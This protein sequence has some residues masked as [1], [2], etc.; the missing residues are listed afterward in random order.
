MGATVKRCRVRGFL[1]GIR[2]RAASSNVIADNTA[3]GNGNQDAHVGYGIDVSGASHNNAFEGNRVQGNADEGIHIGHGSH[4]NRLVGNVIADNYRENLYVLAADGG[5]FLRNTLGSGG[6]NSLYLKDSSFNHFEGNTFLDRTARVIGDAHD[7]VF[8]DN[9][10]L[11][12]GLHFAHYKG[13]PR[14]PTANRV[15]GGAITA[16]ADCLRFTSS[17][18]NVVVDTK[19][20]PCQTGVRAESP[21]GP[22]ENTLVGIDPGAMA[23]D[24]GSTLKV[25]ARVIVHVQDAAGAPVAGAEVQARGA[26]G[27]AFTAVTDERGDIPSQIVITSTRVGGETTPRTPI[28]VTVSKPGYAT[29]VR[30][31][32][33][34]DPLNL[35]VS[36]DPGRG[37]ATGR[38]GPGRR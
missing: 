22:S 8:A 25:G 36:L 20:G 17:G 13:S 5:V 30:T 3:S 28:E 27:A 7:N 35:T 26:T 1:R 33:A 6:V 23:L 24:E 2:L 34:G 21:A 15:T 37:P 32:P 14:H 11:G 18:G 16:A 31:V 9:A 19:L 12:A 29:D 10:F 4:K 38:P